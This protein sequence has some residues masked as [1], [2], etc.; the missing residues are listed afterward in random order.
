MG[1]GHR[2]RTSQVIHFDRSVRRWLGSH[3]KSSISK[4]SLHTKHYF[5]GRQSCLVVGVG[6]KIEF[7][8]GIHVQTNTQL[9]PELG[10]AVEILSFPI[11]RCWLASVFYSDN[12]DLYRWKCLIYS[13]FYHQH[14]RPSNSFK[15]ERVTG[16]IGSVGFRRNEGLALSITWQYSKAEIFHLKGLFNEL[17]LLF[18][19]DIT[20]RGLKTVR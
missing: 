1:R 16:T 5:V 11:A 7:C 8:V 3:V 15:S 10:L 6:T 9:G 12:Q 4:Y 19:L 18:H 14:Y 13:Q 17:L 2:E 20:C